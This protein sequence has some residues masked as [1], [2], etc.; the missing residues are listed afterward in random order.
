MQH[1]IK[2]KA[3][4]LTILVSILASTA[5]ACIFSPRCEL[6]IYNG[7]Q[8]NGFRFNGNDFNLQNQG[9]DLSTIGQQALKK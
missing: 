2:F 4:V 5:T 3:L 7:M 8:I 9:L 6:G 1:N